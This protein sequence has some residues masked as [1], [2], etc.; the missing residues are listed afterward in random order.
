MNVMPLE[1]EQKTINTI[2]LL[3]YGGLIPFIATLSG[4]FLFEGTLRELCL[5]GYIAYAAVILSFVG[6]V[7]WG[8]ILRAKPDNAILLLSL[9]VLPNLTAWVSLLLTQSL[10]LL[11]LL[12]AF[13]LLFF[14]EKVTVLNSLLPDWYMQM[15]LRLTIIVTLTV[16]ITFITTH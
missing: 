8:F 13:P 7:H 2:K 9:S 1:L 4:L 6:A 3:S 14:Y 16:F 12:L 15:R 5:N 11:V 10:S